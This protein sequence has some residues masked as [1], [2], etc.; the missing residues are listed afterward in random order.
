[1][2]HAAGLPKPAWAGRIRQRLRTPDAPQALDPVA[3]SGASSDLNVQ[4]GA[5]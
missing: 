1:M 3:Q 2:P 4:I 5:I